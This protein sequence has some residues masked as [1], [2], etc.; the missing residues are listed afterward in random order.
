MSDITIHMHLFG[1]FRKFGDEV[2]L[3]VPAGASVSLI[4]ERLGLALGGQGT[5]IRDSVLADEQ[6]ILPD[7]F[8][9]TGDTRLSILPP[10]CGG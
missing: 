6:R 8:V 10:V 7:A 4:K 1:A 9:I 5:L 2:R 3:Q